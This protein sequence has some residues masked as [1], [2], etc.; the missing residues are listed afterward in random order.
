MTNI[1]RLPRCGKVWLMTTWKSSAPPW[2]GGAQGSST[3]MATQRNTDVLVRNKLSCAVIPHFL[4]IKSKIRWKCLDKWLKSNISTDALWFWTESMQFDFFAK[5]KGITG[6]S[7][8]V[9]SICRNQCQQ[10]CQQVMA[11]AYRLVTRI[12]QQEVSFLI[13]RGQT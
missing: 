2:G 6:T 11:T 3:M 7:T 10:P 12:C 4:W 13:V 1:L 8:I 9:W 5:S